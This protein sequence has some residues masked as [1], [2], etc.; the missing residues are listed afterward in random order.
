MKPFAVIHSQFRAYNIDNINPLMVSQDKDGKIE[1]ENYKGKYEDRIT[2]MACSKYML[3][4]GRESGILH[5][6]SLP[7]GSLIKR[8]VLTSKPHKIAINCNNT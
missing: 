3:I 2:C 8:H 1:I 5:Q 6:Y 7:D 4:I